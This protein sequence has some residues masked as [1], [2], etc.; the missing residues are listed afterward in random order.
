MQTPYHSL[1]MRKLFIPFVSSISSIGLIIYAFL[2]NER[3][4]IP[5]LIIACVLIGLSI[6]STYYLLSSTVNSDTKEKGGKQSVLLGIFSLSLSLGI[7]I[8]ILSVRG[9]SFELANLISIISTIMLDIL[10]AYCFTQ[11]K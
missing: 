1:A 3:Y 4:T 9:D 8:A 10:T 5:L 11:I 6:G 7:I 2:A